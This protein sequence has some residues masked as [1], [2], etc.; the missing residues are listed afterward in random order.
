MSRIINIQTNP[1]SIAVQR[2]N[3]KSLHFKN[4]VGLFEGKTDRFGAEIVRDGCCCKE[5]ELFTA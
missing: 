3:A 5:I 4:E 2:H 1:L